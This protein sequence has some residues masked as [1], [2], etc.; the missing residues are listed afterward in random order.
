MASSRPVSWVGRSC[1]RRPADFVGTYERSL[2]DWAS[3][4][5]VDPDEAVRVHN[6]L[7]PYNFPWRDLS[8]MRTRVFAFINPQNTRKNG[9][10]PE[11]HLPL[12]QSLED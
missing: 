10:D 3:T 7:N 5:N 9:N 12:D 8:N 6:L 11:D 2:R 4:Y 1:S